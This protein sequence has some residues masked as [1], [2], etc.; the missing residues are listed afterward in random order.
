MAGGGS[1][2]YADGTGSAAQFNYPR[3]V[4]VDTLGNIIVAENGNCLVR[5]ITP[6]GSA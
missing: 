4:S 5:K 1:A 6:A 2:G 3:G